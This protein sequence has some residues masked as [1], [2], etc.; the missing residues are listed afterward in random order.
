MVKREQMEFPPPKK[1]GKKEKSKPKDLSSEQ[2]AFG[3]LTN[4]TNN[5]P[6]TSSEIT[7]LILKQPTISSKIDESH[8]PNNTVGFYLPTVP[9]L[10]PDDGPFEGLVFAFFWPRFVLRYKAAYRGVER[11]TS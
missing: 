3:L 2:W 9:F 11:C 7:S 10:R 6:M 4:N 5:S 8:V 1:K